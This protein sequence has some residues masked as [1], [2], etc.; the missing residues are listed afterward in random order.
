MRR[1]LDIAV[2]GW[3]VLAASTAAQ[4]PCD[5]LPPPA[6]P[7]VDVFP[8]DAGQLRSIVAGAA[9]GT[10]LLLHDGFYDL[11]HGDSNDRLSF[12][13]P[14]VTLRSASGN[15]SAVVLDGDYTTNELISIHASNVTIADLTVRRAFHHPIHVSGQAGA[16]IDGV[17]LHNLHV[18]DPGEQ[19]IKIN[20][21]GDGYA[22]N[23]VVECSLI[24]LTDLGRLEIR[25]NCY[26]G[27]IDAH[28]AWGWVVRRNRI[29]GFWCD[30]GLSEHA[31]HFWSASRDTLVEENAIADCARG[32]GF[33]LGSSGADRTYADNPYPGVGYLGHIDGTIRNNFVAAN[34]PALF[35]SVSGFDTGVGLEQA[36]GTVVFHNS[37]ASTE[38]PAS[39][40][41]EWRFPN[42][43]A[44]IANNLASD[45]LLE[46]N[47]GVASLA[48]NLE[49]VALSWFTDVAAGDLHLTPAATGAVDGGTT[50][51][52]G[53]ADLDI[54]LE[55]R[56][57]SPDVGADEVG[58]T[59]FADGFESGDTS[60]W[61]ATV[62]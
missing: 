9:A 16:P 44:E 43:L 51:P 7:V 52:P 1:A 48:T 29:T 17:V 61:S 3:L 2:L 54:D 36:R 27:G 42:T 40:S 19:A 32:I 53:L 25:N 45:R 39:S 46:R 57:S 26:T 31:I 55:P 35:A 60:G 56:D 22:D 8:A 15:R 24:E 12:H 37:V 10:T 47:G 33:G 14:G 30:Q 21:V 38:A 50:L 5:P 28:K 11:S 18:V 49:H 59:I 41:I 58:D 23:G 20:A 6:G 4:P 13:T 34:D 62:P